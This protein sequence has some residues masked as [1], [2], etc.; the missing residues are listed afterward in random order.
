MSNLVGS[1]VNQIAVCDYNSGAAMRDSKNL[2]SAVLTFTGA[3]W[4]A[5]TAGIRAGDF[6]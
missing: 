5:F 2:G 1:T 6:E 4:S 3:E